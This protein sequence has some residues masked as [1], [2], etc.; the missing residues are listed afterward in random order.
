MA[1]MSENVPARVHVCRA[2]VVTSLALASPLSLLW[3]LHVVLSAMHLYP[4]WFASGFIA[5][6]G[7]VLFGLLLIAVPWWLYETSR[8]ISA[9]H[10]LPLPFSPAKG[11]SAFYLP[12]QQI[13]AP[14]CVMRSLT[15]RASH[16]LS[17]L[18]LVKTWWYSWLVLFPAGIVGFMYMVSSLSVNFVF[19]TT[20]LYGSAAVFCYLTLKLIL[21][22]EQDLENRE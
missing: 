5:R 12:V 13:Y 20:W 17:S 21:R 2:F 11:A 7:W 1:I 3:L 15:F 19:L 4:L 8:R 14:Y 10:Y 9:R 16:Q 18:P 22:I 6:A